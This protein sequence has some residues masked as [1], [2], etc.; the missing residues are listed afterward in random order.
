MVIPMCRPGRIEVALAH[1]GAEYEPPPGWE[2]RVIL[3]VATEGRG[4]PR[5]SIVVGPTTEIAAFAR[6]R[7]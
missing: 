1:L 3:T 5:A 2:R 7:T 4:G 6:R